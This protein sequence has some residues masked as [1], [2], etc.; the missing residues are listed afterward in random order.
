[1][2]PIQT[3]HLHRAKA[4]LEAAGASGNARR[5]LDAFFRLAKACA[6][7]RHSEAVAAELLRSSDDRLHRI[8]KSTAL[9]TGD[10]PAAE[11]EALAAAY[12]A[13]IADLSL[14]DSLAIY[15]RTLPPRLNHSLVAADSVVSLVD[16][17]A[18]KPVIVPGLSL[19]DAVSFKPAAIVVWSQELDR[20]SAAAGRQMLEREMTSAVTRAMNSVVVDHFN[21]TSATPI[22]GTGDPLNDL[23]AGLQAAPG[24]NGYVA[25]V[26]AGAAAD[27]ATRIENRNMGVRGGQ[28]APG[29]HVVAV[30]DFSG[31]LVI[32]ASRVAIRDFGLELRSTSH[33]DVDL[34]DTP[35]SPAQLTSLWQTNCYGLLVEREFALG[36]DAVAVYVTGG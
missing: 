30:D 13:S 7:H 3:A 26:G 12:L 28:F 27:L 1:M 6:S 17:G 33:A 34:R 36:G 4:A 9:I 19:A 5:D 21:D 25:V 31:T 23:R 20:A 24:S 11:A 35:L 18:P 16:E 32:P 14:L 8:A 15:A 22:T 2:D 10:W 29:V